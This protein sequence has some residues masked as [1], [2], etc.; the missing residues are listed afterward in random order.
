MKTILYAA[1]T[2]IPRLL[3]NLR[4]SNEN[5]ESIREFSN[6]DT[7]YKNRLEKRDQAATLEGSRAR[8]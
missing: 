6:V 5:L 3:D 2:V 7:I 4:A 8:C 1:L